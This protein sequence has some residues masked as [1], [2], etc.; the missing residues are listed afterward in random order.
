[1]R[2]SMCAYMCGLALCMPYQVLAEEVESS[3]LIVSQELILT[4][5]KE[6]EERIQQMAIQ[7]VANMAQGILAIG[8]NPHDPQVVSQNIAGI[9]GSFAGLV[10]YA[11]KN[12]E[13]FS[14]LHSEKFRC[15]LSKRLEEVNEKS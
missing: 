2:M 4:K 9:L 1:M 6:E 12:P 13:F 7:T 10:A 15:L 11:M 14:L 3:D 5:E 8:N